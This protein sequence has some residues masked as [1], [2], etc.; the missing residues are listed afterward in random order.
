MWEIILTA[1]GLMLILEGIPPLL[2]PKS[3]RDMLRMVAR[4]KPLTLRILGLIA[5]LVGAVLM[6]LV[7]K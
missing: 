6:Y 7:H 4:R 2:M 5:I 1:L 3:Y